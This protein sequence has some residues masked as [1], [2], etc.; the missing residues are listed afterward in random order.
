MSGDSAGGNLTATTTYLDPAIFKT[1]F[2]KR[3]VLYYPDVTEVTKQRMEYA[4]SK[5]FT[6]KE[7][8]DQLKKFINFFDGDT[9]ANDMYRGKHNRDEDLISI[10]NA[11]H[12]EKMPPAELIAGEFDPLRPQGE[13]FINKLKDLNIETYYVRYNGMSHAFLDSLGYYPQ[14]E[15]SIIE[16]CKFLNK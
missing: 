7:M 11:D 1:N 14:A 13:T 12:L 3:I 2:L 10:L 6:F 5:F 8:E 9:L 4:D 16:G 15:D